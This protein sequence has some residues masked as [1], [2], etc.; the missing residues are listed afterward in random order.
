[1]SF[2]FAL[3]AASGKTSDLS[4]KQRADSSSG[5]H[6][7]TFTG[8]SSSWI[9]DSILLSPSRQHHLLTAPIHDVNDVIVVQTAITGEADIICTNDED[10]FEKPAAQYL[11]NHGISVLDEIAL[12]ERLRS[13]RSTF[14]PPVEPVSHS[15]CFLVNGATFAS[16]RHRAAVAGPL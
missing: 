15:P 10:C 8:R 16:R 2:A 12:R 5:S 6:I 14:L 13:W 4:L 11:S 1:M 9:I 3:S 7:R